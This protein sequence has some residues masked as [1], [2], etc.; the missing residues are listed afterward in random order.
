M[1][2]TSSLRESDHVKPQ[3]LQSLGACSILFAGWRSWIS[4]STSMTK[5]L[6]QR[7]EID[8]VP[9]NDVLAADP[10]AGGGPAYQLPEFLL[11]LCRFWRISLWH[12]Q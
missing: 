9:I 2:F 10:S 3:F 6:R 5:L 7:Y 4:P 1:Q 11:G 12:G 8:D